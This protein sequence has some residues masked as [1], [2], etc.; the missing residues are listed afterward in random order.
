MACS[1]QVEI[2]K[3]ADGK[4]LNP[5]IMIRPALWLASDG[6]DGITGGRFMAQHWDDKGS[7]KA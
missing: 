5:S 4:L 6:S 1:H 7:L 3:D 2:K